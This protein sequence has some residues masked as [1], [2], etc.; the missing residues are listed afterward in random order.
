[1]TDTTGVTTWAYD[2]RGRVI[3]ETR[4]LANDLGT[5]TTQWRYDAAG[6][7]TAMQYPDPSTSSGQGG[8][9]VRSSYDARGLVKSV[10][11]YTPGDEL[12]V[13]ASGVSYNPLGQ[14]E[15]MRLGNGLLTQYTYDDENFRLEH[16]QLPDLLD[17]S[18]GYDDVGNVT[19]IQDI[20]RGEA[21]TFTYD[22]LDRLLAASGA[23][24][25]SF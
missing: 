9:V 13:Y 17:L 25:E 14:M 2:A 22:A 11:G 24:A 4:T 8:E 3:S 5:Y 23:H 6:R 18:Y 12:W 20:T 1:M 10:T 19:A 15:A 7:V 21:H 16:I